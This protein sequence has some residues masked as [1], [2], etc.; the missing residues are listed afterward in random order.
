MFTIGIS[1]GSNLILVT[2]T[3]HLECF[4]TKSSPELPVPFV[5]AGQ[6]STWACFYLPCTAI[7]PECSKPDVVFN[8]G[9][10]VAPC[11]DPGCK[12]RYNCYK[13]YTLVGNS[14]R[15]CGNDGQWDVDTPICASKYSLAM[16][17]DMYIMS[18]CT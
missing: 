14:V 10:V 5:S 13:D 6:S 9:D 7:A 16:N 3:H 8:N 4:G 11:W 17:S 2:S 12:A 1:I 18:V 15:T